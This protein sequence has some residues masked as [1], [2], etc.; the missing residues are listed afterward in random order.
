MSLGSCKHT[1]E[2]A[3]SRRSSLSTREKRLGCMDLEGRLKP[4]R[5]KYL[6]TKFAERCRS[7]ERIATGR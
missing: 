4:I 2:S 3:G 1:I 7:L 5:D 6:A